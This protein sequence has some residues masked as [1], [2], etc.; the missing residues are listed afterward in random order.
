MSEIELA[1]VTLLVVIGCVWPLLALMMCFAVLQ[2]MVELFKEPERYL[3]NRRDKA[4]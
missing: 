2:E 3:D 1:L 4:E